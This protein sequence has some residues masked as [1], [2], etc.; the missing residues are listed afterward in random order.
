MKGRTRRAGR[1]V[2]RLTGLV[3]RQVCVKPQPS[4]SGSMDSSEGG[5]LCLTHG[6]PESYA[7]SLNLGSLSLNSDLEV[8]LMFSHIETLTMNGIKWIFLSPAI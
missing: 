1:R 8:N 6:H 2:L 3:G 7:C 4:H 5:T